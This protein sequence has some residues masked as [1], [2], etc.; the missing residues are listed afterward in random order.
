MHAGLSAAVTS[1]VVGLGGWHTGIAASLAI[2]GAMYARGV[3][4]LWRGGKRRAIDP[5]Q[6]TSF[7]VAWL[8]IF[9]VLASPLE[10]LAEEL[11]TAHMIQHE[12]LMVVAAPLLVLGRPLVVMLWALPANRRPV[13]GRAIKAVPVRRTWHALT[14]PMDAWLLHAAAIWIWHI[15]ALFE[16]ALRSEVAHAA[17]HISFVA[18]GLLFWWVIIYPRRRSAGGMSVLYLFTTAVHTG[19]LGA[20]MTFARTPWY[21][22]Y[23]GHGTEWGLTPLA[24]QQLAGMVMWIPA[25]IAYL[26]AA[27]L[28]VR[29]WLADSEWTVTQRDRVAFGLHPPEQD[30]RPL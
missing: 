15:P 19:V 16:T 27:L 11:F 28:V 3:M 7:A 14:R 29:R 18:S 2:G 6:V 23:A 22:T 1:S 17:Q 21:S 12:L 20:L 25:S 5:W 24:D 10:E 8:T 26:I 13:V 4:V 9:V 30:P